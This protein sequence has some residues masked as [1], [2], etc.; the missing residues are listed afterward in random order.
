[1]GSMVRIAPTEGHGRIGLV[2]RTHAFLKAVYDKFR[3]DLCALSGEER[4][5]MAFRAVNEVPNSTTGILTTTLVFGVFPKL[6]GADNRV[7]MAQRAH[8]IR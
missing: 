1:M 3:I 8:I 6:P 4:L 7:E 2:E 5:S